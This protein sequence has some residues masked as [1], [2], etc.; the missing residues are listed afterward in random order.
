[1][2]KSDNKVLEEMLTELAK[3]GELYRPS[4]FWIKL[5]RIHLQHLSN[6]GIDH[7]K[8]SI[9]GKYFSWGTLGILR[10]QLWP[11][12]S[13]LSKGNFLP[14]LKSNFND[15]NLNLGKTVRRFNTV[16]SQIY[17]IYVAYLFDY[18]SKVD[19]YQILK[20]LDE[21][22]IGNPF[23]INYKGRSISQDLCNSVHEF[24][25]IM[26]YIPNFK[27]MDI[28]ELGSG[29]GRL[30]F[31]FLKAFPKSSY[32][33]IDIPPAL[34]IAQFYISKI[35]PKE[36]IFKFRSFSSFKEV[37][38]EFEE[39]R[40]RFLMPHQ[41]ELLPKKYFDLLINISSLHEMTRVQIK[42]YI[43][44]I[45]RLCRG[46]FYTK[47]WRKSWTADNNFIKEKEYPIPKKWKILLRRKKHPIQGMF[48]D[49]VYKI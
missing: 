24:S 25:S 23:I 11:I 36:K 38:K 30:S 31:I 5:N 34:Y 46:Y 32:C 44:Q 47:Q 42:N 45:D 40:I 41:I 4:L 35:F 37:K 26:E 12:L 14:I 19:K 7:F 39:S 6:S 49:T 13:I 17:R 29:Y 9:S 48:F 3:A 10:H 16:A 1:M 15:Y 22:Q 28:A 33:F 43:N 2:V 27:K 8:R 18:V 21:P 20:K